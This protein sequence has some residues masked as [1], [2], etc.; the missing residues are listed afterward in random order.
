MSK[1]SKHLR[2]CP[3]LRRA[4]TPVEC[5]SGRGSAYQC[6]AACPFFPFTPANYD[7]HGEIEG[8][9]IEK[10]YARAREMTD[11]E[12]DSML[13]VLDESEG[14]AVDEV[15][16]NH[17]RFAWLYHCRRDAEGRTFGERWLADKNSG[18][19]NDERVLLAGMNAMRPAS[20]R[21]PPHCR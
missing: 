6:P 5:G 11:A 18:L 16:A 2:E 14:G 9:L 19:S 4:I 7:K 12:R 21:S 17:A 20:A 1:A 3:A 8:R 10:T 13:R 15:L